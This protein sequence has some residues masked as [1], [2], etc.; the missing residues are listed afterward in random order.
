MKQE[1]SSMIRARTDIFDEYWNLYLELSIIMH[2]RWRL[3]GEVMDEILT[4]V[5]Y[6]AFPHYSWGEEIL[7]ERAKAAKRV[8]GHPEYYD[9]Y[10]AL[11][12]QVKDA[13]IDLM[14]QYVESVNILINYG[15]LLMEE[16]AVVN[17][18]KKLLIPATTTKCD[19]CVRKS[20][21]K[22]PVC[23]QFLCARHYGAFWAIIK[24]GACTYCKRTNRMPSKLKA[25]MK[26]AALLFENENGEPDAISGGS[27][28]IVSGHAVGHRDLS[29]S[30]A[31]ME[32]YFHL[33]YA[34][35]SPPRVIEL[36]VEVNERLARLKE[37]INEQFF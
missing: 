9:D 27:L 1:L 10:L 20:A 3:H 7:K 2:D 19:H 28:R 12:A 34:R 11:I 21:I 31:Q 6:L 25:W 35:I 30:Y 23:K 13:Q 14:A 16:E 17:R 29:E 36:G 22:C 4:Y 26:P 15:F 18:L 32:K 33:I 24:H 5:Q 37:V 8:D